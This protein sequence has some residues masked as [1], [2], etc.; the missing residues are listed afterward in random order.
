M[1]ILVDNG[2]HSSSFMQLHSLSVAHLNG[3]IVEV[4]SKIIDAQGFT[5]YVC[6]LVPSESNNDFESENKMKV[7]LDNLTAI[8][9][10][11]SNDE[12]IEI[13]KKLDELESKYLFAQNDQRVAAI[14]KKKASTGYQEIATIYS[15]YK[16]LARVWLLKASMALI[17]KTGSDRTNIYLQCMRRGVANIRND[18]SMTDEKRHSKILPTLLAYSSS[19]EDFGRPD[20]AQS[21]LKMAVTSF[22]NHHSIVFLYGRLIVK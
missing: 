9:A 17:F 10:I 19:A 4:G 20:I 14:R 18:F 6:I 22:P 8:P 1:D 15:T 3:S 11:T 5:R 2:I 16:H 21:A 7:K 12:V 13:G